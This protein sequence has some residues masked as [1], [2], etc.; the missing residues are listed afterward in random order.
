MLLCLKC[1]KVYNQKTIKNNQCKLKECNG[2]VV[3]IDELFISVI[4]ELNRKGYSTLFCCS[5]H[6][7]ESNSNS[8][9]FFEDYIKL[10]SLPQGYLYDQDMYPTVD[11]SKWQVKNTIRKVFDDKKSINDLSRD[12]FENALSVLKWAEGL[13]NLS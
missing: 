13:E 2:K 7:G 12:I 5:G 11:W 6:L 10:S 3:E 4:A 9:I 1:N 8:Y